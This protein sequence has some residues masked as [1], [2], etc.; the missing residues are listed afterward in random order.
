MIG[1]LSNFFNVSESTRDFFETNSFLKKTIAKVALVAIGL[2]ASI[3]A[4]MPFSLL[5]GV[6]TTIGVFSLFSSSDTPSRRV[7][8]RTYYPS[9]PN[10]SFD[11][12][13]NSRTHASTFYNRGC[14]VHT[15]PQAGP[16]AQVGG[17]YCS[18]RSSTQRTFRDSAP[19]SFPSHQ[20]TPQVGA[21]AQVGSSFQ[22]GSRVQ[23][24]E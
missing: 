10:Y 16:R 3:A 7:Y 22:S 21:R 18:M 24:G 11:P 19:S 17:D 20:N 4:P 15:S 6:A 13:R 23:P 1:P 8:S 14:Q 5:A 2:F 9:Y 12:W